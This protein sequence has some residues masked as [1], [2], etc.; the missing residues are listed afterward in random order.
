MVLLFPHLTP[1][2]QF[3]GVNKWQRVNLGS[4]AQDS[5]GWFIFTLIEALIADIVT[6]NA[7]DLQY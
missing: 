5:K 2:H 7:I 1:L 3:T 4:G 6:V